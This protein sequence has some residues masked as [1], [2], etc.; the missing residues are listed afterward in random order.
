MRAVGYRDAGTEDH[1]GIDGHVAADFRVVAKEHRF[2]CPQRGA[3]LHRFLALER[4]PLRFRAGEFGAGVDPGDLR[5]I[6]GDDD[7]ALAPV[8][9]RD[10][11]HV[12]EVVLA[13]RV[14]VADAGEQVEQIRSARCH[15]P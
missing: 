14:V 3:A 13:R 1:V 4:L 10:V 7:R 2:G 15:Q 12:D 8:L 11:D 9:T 5:R 6:V